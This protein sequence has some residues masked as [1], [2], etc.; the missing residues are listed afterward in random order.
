MEPQLV[1]YNVLKNLL[2]NSFNET[3]IPFTTVIGKYSVNL[4]KDNWFF[5]LIIIL[6]IIIIIFSLIKKN[7]NFMSKENELEYIDKPSN[8]I[9]SYNNKYKKNKE[10]YIN[11][12]EYY[13]NTPRLYI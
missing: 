11:T 6:I 5:F 9:E 13:T 3:D 2:K 8:I 4:I 7:E 10:K 1:E 12:N